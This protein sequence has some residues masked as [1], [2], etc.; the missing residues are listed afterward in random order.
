MSQWANIDTI[1]EFMG[2]KADTKNLQ[3]LFSQIQS[4]AK[5]LFL[6]TIKYYHNGIFL[7]ILI[8][9]E[10]PISTK[11]HNKKNVKKIRRFVD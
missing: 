9:I 7:Y 5:R 3:I 8:A 11:K 6:V 1:I 4:V 10:N 2:S